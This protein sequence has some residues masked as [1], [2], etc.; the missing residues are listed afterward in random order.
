MSSMT[1]SPLNI[2]KKTNFNAAECTSTAD[3]TTASEENNEHQ[4][5]HCR[6]QSLLVSFNRDLDRILICLLHCENF[7]VHLS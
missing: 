6:S 2:A 4:T 5:D 3:N 1:M 7:N